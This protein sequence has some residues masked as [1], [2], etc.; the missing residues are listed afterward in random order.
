MDSTNCSRL[1]DRYAY[2]SLNDATRTR[3]IP[4]PVMRQRASGRAGLTTA[5]HSRCIKVALHNVANQ[6]TMYIT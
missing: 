4:C 1:V 5:N 3:I 2:V 6:K